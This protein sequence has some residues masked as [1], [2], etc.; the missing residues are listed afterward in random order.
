MVF[1]SFHIPKP[2]TV[3]IDS[4]L[5]TACCQRSIPQ[6]GTHLKGFEINKSVAVV[7]RERIR[8]QKRRCR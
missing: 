7:E 2:G 6:L 8:D 5:A 4:S 1:L 3:M